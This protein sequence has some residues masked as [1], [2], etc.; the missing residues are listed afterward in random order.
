MKRAIAV[1]VILTGISVVSM[2]Y[3][4]GGGPPHERGDRMSRHEIL[5]KLSP[6]AEML[7]HSTMRDAREKTAGV[8]DEIKVLHREIKDI[9]TAPVFDENLFR[10]KVKKVGDLRQKKHAAMQEA[11]VKLA[12]Q[13]TQEE[14]G[15]LV[16]LMSH[17][18]GHHGRTGA[19][20]L[21]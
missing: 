15:V 6:E 9:V 5:T 2:A 1:T 18:H 14:R 12:K 4:F 19:G 3:A 13:L 7:F 16:Q 20:R 21:Q 11:V 8:R 10:E 17:R